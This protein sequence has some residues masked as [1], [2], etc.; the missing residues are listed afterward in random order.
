MAYADLAEWGKGVANAVEDM[1]RQPLV[2]L[3]AGHS[4]ITKE[5]AHN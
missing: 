1:Q 2:V 4:H 3:R 5:N